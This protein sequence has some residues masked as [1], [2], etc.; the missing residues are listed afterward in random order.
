MKNINIINNTDFDKNTILVTKVLRKTCDKNFHGLNGDIIIE[1]YDC[2]RVYLRCGDN[3]YTIRTWNIWNS[4]NGY[5]IEWTFYK[6]VDDVD[7]LGR[8]YSHGI[9]LSYGVSKV[10]VDK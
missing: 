1:D 10:E 3:E 7:E 8:K 2:D 6:F 9:D 4:G 5:N